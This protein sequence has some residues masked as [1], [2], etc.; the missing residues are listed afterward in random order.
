MSMYVSSIMVS[1][2]VQGNRSF[3]KIKNNK[4]NISFLS[5]E[6]VSLTNQP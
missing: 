4:K 2:E 3:L 5:V 1:D 6:I